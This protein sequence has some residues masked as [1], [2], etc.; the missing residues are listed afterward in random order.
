MR[1][2]LDRTTSEVDDKEAALDELRRS[3]HTLKAEVQLAELRLGHLKGE[4]Q[5][6]SQENERLRMELRQQAEQM[7]QMVSLGP[8]SHPGPIP[9][10]QSPPLP[11]P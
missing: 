10:P 1:E 8:N 2:E 3:T 6:A 4:W 5:A 11:Y 7:E 9:R